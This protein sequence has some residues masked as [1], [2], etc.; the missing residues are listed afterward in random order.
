MD[1]TNRKFG[2]TNINVPTLAVIHDGVAF[3]LLITMLNK[4]GNS[5][6]GGRI[7]IMNRFIRLFGK[8]RIDCLT[9][10][11]E[12]VGEVWIE[13]LNIN[14]IPCFIRIRNN[15]YADRH[16]KTVKASW[17]FAHLRCGQGEVLRPV[18]AVNGLHGYLSGSKIKNRD[19]E[20]ELQIIISFNYNALAIEIYKQRWQ[21]ETAFREMKSSGFNI[22]D[23]HLADIDRIEKPFSIVMVALA[24]AYVAGIYV[25]DNVKK[26]RVKNNGKHVKSL[27]KYGLE[28]IR[29][30]P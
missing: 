10:D 23:T 26:I 2:E 20:P 21:I 1:R 24:W 18:C 16:G 19:G 15:F 11:R 3:P 22:E 25:N 14:R 6:T 27:F 8:D 17:L 28:F 13:Y 4:R 5:H 12:F 7:E 9:A 29:L 30:L